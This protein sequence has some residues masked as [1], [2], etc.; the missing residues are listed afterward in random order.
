[1]NGVQCRSNLSQTCPN[2]QPIKV[3]EL[4]KSAKDVFAYFSQRN[5]AVVNFTF[6]VKFNKIGVGI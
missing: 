5:F 4:L 2:R 6:L 1:M 3:R